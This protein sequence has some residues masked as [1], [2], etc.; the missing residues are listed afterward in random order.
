MKARKIV[1]TSLLAVSV[2]MGIVSC[3]SSSA[4]ALPHEEK[5]Q[6]GAKHTVDSFL[7]QVSTDLSEYESSLT[8][9]NTE[10]D[11]INA[12]NDAFKESAG[13][14]KSGA[15]SPEDTQSLLSSFAQIYVYDRDAKI[16]SQESDYKVEGNT[17]SINGS[18]FHV[19]LDGKVQEHPT[20]DKSNGKLTLTYDG[21]KWLISGFDSGK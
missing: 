9:K 10:A 2:S 11:K 13:Y 19:T 6:A 18:D 8:G 3:T 4:P 14:V 21:S 1:L 12:F 15:F 7:T 17:A 20:A 16:E 5:T